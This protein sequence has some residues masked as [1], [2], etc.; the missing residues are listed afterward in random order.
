D[1]HYV[2]RRDAA[3]GHAVDPTPP[4]AYPGAGRAGGLG[5]F[6]LGRMFRGHGHPSGLSPS[7]VDAAR[8]ARVG[9]LA[10]NR[11][12]RILIESAEPHP[13]RISLRLSCGTVPR[14]GEL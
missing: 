12:M 9:G 14:T 7:Q 8:G 11:V 6:R 2:G 13:F 3:E 4:R 10:S 1:Q 5:S